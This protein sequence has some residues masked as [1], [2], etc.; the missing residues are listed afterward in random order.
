MVRPSPFC[1]LDEVDAALDEANVE[2]FVKL[3]KEFATKS[4]F[5]IIS[6]NKRT[7]EVADVIYGVTMAEQGVSQTL[8]VEMSKPGQKPVADPVQKA[9]GA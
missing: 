9:E 5:L 8:S 1:M 6:H 2:R 3:L 4:Q 7:M